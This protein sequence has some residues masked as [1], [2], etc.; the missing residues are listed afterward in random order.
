M[1]NLY[2]TKAIR[3]VILIIRFTNGKHLA[4]HRGDI[5]EEERMVEFLAPS[6]LFSCQNPINIAYSLTTLFCVFNTTSLTELTRCTEVHPVEIS[7]NFP[8]PS[9]FSMTMFLPQLI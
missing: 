4:L 1:K 3:V 2:L 9:P 6:S 8:N 7:T 5:N